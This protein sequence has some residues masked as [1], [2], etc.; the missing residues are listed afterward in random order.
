[1]KCHQ[2]ESA[3]LRS[4]VRQLASYSTL[5]MA[6]H[7]Y[8]EDGNFHYHDPNVTTTEYRCSNGHMWPVHSAPTCRA[9]GCD[10]IA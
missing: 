4:T 9:P 7:W 6:E 1:M 3:G 10:F 8:D 5:L 2:C